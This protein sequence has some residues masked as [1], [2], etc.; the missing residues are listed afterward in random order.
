VGISTRGRQVEATVPLAFGIAHASG[1]GGMLRA[2]M[3]VGPARDELQVL[4][5]T[6]AAGPAFHR[7]L[8][9]RLALGVAVLAGAF[10]HRYRYGVGT[11]RTEPALAVEVPLWATIRLAAGFTVGLEVDIGISGTRW[12]HVVGSRT[13][14]ARPEFRFGAGATLG[15]CWGW[16]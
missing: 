9:S 16:S 2:A 5:A 7:P 8:G 15:W 4:D 14:W 11:P 12:E 6:I 3:L 10:L 13:V 1:F